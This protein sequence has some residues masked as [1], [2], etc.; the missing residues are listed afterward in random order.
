MITKNQAIINEERATVFNIQP[1][2]T[3]DG[4]GV[5]TTVFLKG[6]NLS[7]LWCHNPE[8]INMKPQLQFN[9]QKCIGCKKCFAACKNHAHKTDENSAHVIDKN[10][11]VGCLSCVKNCCAQALTQVGEL[12]TAKKVF[13]QVLA[14]KPYYGEHGGLTVSGGECLLNPH[15][16][17]ELFTLCKQND[18]STAIDTAGNVDFGVI[19][20]LLSLTDYFL[21]DIKAVN[22]DVHRRL[23]GVG[24]ELILANLD[25][26]LELNANVIVRIPC[27][28]GANLDD[29]KNAPQLFLKKK[30]MQVE[31]LPYHRL[32]EGKAQTLL[33]D[34][35]HFDVPT[36][37]QMSELVSLFTKCKIPVVSN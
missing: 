35:R 1:F 37:L 16:L 22:S 31:L 2:S 4:P 25:K 6:C 29:L 27:I 32:G 36:D 7:C 33:R 14:D 8:S 13:E 17:K 21:Y 10:L 18:L 5:R 3:Q 11:C 19:E 9:S 15:F 24:N 20:P 30:P 28:P 12:M 34:V 23:T 26:L